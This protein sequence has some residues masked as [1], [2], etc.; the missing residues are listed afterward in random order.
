MLSN[1]KLSY[2]DKEIMEKGARAL[3]KEPGYS[4]F[5]RFIRFMDYEGEDYLKM[6]DEIYKYVS[7]EQ[8]YDEAEK[9]W[10]KNKQKWSEDESEG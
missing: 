9:H 6:Q 1:K 10:E 3:I 5:L 7:L 2:S 8:M 4:G